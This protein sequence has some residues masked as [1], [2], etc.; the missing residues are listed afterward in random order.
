MSSTPRTYD[1]IIFGAT[2]YTGKLTSK[3]IL[4]NS[5]TTLKW[6]IAGRSSQKLEL[7]AT[8]YNTTYPDRQP[9]GA[10]S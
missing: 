10:S 6:A 5:P 1:L 4:L 7:L 2:G 3:Q 9:V 8:D